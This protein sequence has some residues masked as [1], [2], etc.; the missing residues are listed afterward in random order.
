VLEEEVP[1]FTIIGDPQAYYHGD[2]GWF[3]DQIKFVLADG[4][5]TPMRLTGV[6][7]KEAG[8]WKVVQWHF[9]IGVANVDTAFGD[10]TL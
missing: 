2:V 6:L 9:S 5:E 8:E 3:A 4:S 1:N 10:I 7:E